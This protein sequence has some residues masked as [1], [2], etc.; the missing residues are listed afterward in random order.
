ME[1]VIKIR[2][3]KLPDP[4]KI[5]NCGSFFKNPIISSAHFK[6]LKKY[7]PKIVSYQVS[8]YKFKIAAGWL[9][10]NAGLKGFKIGN[11]GTHQKQA[12]V[13]VNYGNATGL[14]IK[15]L[16]EKFSQKYFKSIKSS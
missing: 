1:T 5:G 8:K 15:E 16:A 11:A 7:F 10:E 14:E 3:K 4:N 12:L 13:I 2:T 6:N 9:I